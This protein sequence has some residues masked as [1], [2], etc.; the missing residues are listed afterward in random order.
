MILSLLMD[1]LLVKENNL[2]DGYD[3]FPG[4]V[5][6]NNQHNNRYGKVH[7]GDAWEPA[8]KYYCGN[9]KEFMPISLIVFGDKTHMDLHGSLSVIPI[10]SYSHAS[11]VRVEIIIPSGD[12]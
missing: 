9:S 6:G 7:T 11:T 2:A 3:L 8:Q 4:E 12:Q 1:K 5:D 10:F